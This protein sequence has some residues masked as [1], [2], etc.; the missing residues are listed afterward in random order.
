MVRNVTKI[1]GIFALTEMLSFKKLIK[2]FRI[3]GPS[4]LQ[5]D[6]EMI[7]Q[8]ESLSAIDRDYQNALNYFFKSYASNITQNKDTIISTGLI[9]LAPFFVYCLCAVFFIGISHKNAKYLYNPN[10]LD[11]NIQTQLFLGVLQ[12]QLIGLA[13]NTGR[14]FCRRRRRRERKRN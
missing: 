5:L 9:V 11:K 10:S 7:K 12:S 6:I 3:H 8:N 14:R 13:V 4:T 1:Y 2:T